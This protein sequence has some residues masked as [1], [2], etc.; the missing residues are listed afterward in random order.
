MNVLKNEQ[1]NM[2]K[3]YWF[4]FIFIFSFFTNLQSSENAEKI[5][6]QIEQ[7]IYQK[8]VNYVNKH[9]LCTPKK[10]FKGWKVFIKHEFDIDF[11][12]I[13]DHPIL[14]IVKQAVQNNDYEVC[15]EGVF[16]CWQEFFLQNKNRLIDFLVGLLFITV[17]S[18]IEGEVSPS[19]FDIIGKKHRIFLFIII[20]VLHLYA[21][22]LSNDKIDFLLKNVIYLGPL[23]YKGFS[24]EVVAAYMTWYAVNAVDHFRLW[25]KTNVYFKINEAHINNQKRLSA[26]SKDC[27]PVLYVVSFLLKS[28]LGELKDEECLFVDKTWVT[29]N[30]VTTLDDNKSILVTPEVFNKL[31]GHSVHPSFFG[32][33]LIQ[34]AAIFGVLSVSYTTYNI[35]RAGKKLLEKRMQQN[36]KKNNDYY[37]KEEFELLIKK[38]AR[39]EYE[40]NNE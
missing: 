32:E 10:I 34:W 28:V 25:K 17:S 40:Y 31:R 11:E 26:F 14:G 2:K 19:S 18:S 37:T 16:N 24:N 1:K 8:W 20:S 23:L 4:F 13:K 9:E 3:T 39:N 21:F 30:P 12:D 15:N 29:S 33:L 7:V 38:S 22:C 6:Y 35:Y 36:S 27:A 5:I